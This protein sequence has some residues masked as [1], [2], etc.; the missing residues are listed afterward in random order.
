LTTSK[1]GLGTLNITINSEKDVTL[2]FLTN[3]FEVEA[4]KVAA[5]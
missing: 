4:L 1:D 2:V 5:L 3:N